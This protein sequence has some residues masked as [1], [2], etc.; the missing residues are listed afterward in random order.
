KRRSDAADV[1]IDIEQVL[2]S[3]ASA[4]V[5]PAAQGSHL[6]WI[7]TGALALVA[8]VLAIPAVRYIR[9]APPK[10]QSYRFQIGPPPN[11]RVSTFRLSSDGRYVAFIAASVTGRAGEAGGL[12][13]VGGTG[14]GSLW[15]R[16]LDS[17]ESRMIPG[18]EGSSYPFWSPDNAFVG[19]FEGGKLK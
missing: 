11:T 18:T 10:P 13:G 7:V 12:A 9:E 16:A 4:P 6:A 8:V 3:P 14:E 17:L 5:T 19:F 1:R 15:I 2:A